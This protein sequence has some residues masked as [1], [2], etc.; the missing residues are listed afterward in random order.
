MVILDV[1]SS[2]LGNLSFTPYFGFGLMIFVTG[3]QVGSSYKFCSVRS[4]SMQH[5]PF[6]KFKFRVRVKKIRTTEFTLREFHTQVQQ[7]A[8][9][10]VSPGGGGEEGVLP[11][12]SHI[13]MC[14]PIKLGFCA[15]LVRKRVYTLPILVWHRVWF[16][17]ELQECM[18]VFIVSIPKE[19]KRKK[20][21]ICEFE[22]DL[23]NF[24]V[25]SL[26]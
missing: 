13:G 14:R 12:I 6:Y 7:P 22:M 24:F 18:N 26:I 9:L 2:S 25:C 17:R 11:Y 16:S 20:R 10:A 19:R 23:K 15:V 8:K 5:M 3:L 4:V 1:F 21:E